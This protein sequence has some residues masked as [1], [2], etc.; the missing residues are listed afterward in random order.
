MVNKSLLHDAGSAIVRTPLLWFFAIIYC[1]TLDLP[2]IV[3]KPPPWFIFLY[4]LLFPL[5]ILAPAC[6]IRAIQLQ[7]FSAAESV[8][9]IIR[10]CTRRI[11]ALIVV[12]LFSGLIALLLLGI[13]GCPLSLILEQ[14]TK[15]KMWTSI[16]DLASII[17]LPIMVFAQCAIVISSLPVRSSIL[18]LFKVIKKDT[19]TIL[20]LIVVFGVLRY[21]MGTI[22]PTIV[23]HPIRISGYLLILLILEGV[24]AAFFTIAYL[25]Y[26]LKDTATHQPAI[27]S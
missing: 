21:I 1:L 27:S 13:I 12:L 20:T 23:N 26:L 7:Y 25:H 4:I 17:A 11:G 6:Q 19:F 24:Q 10:F 14:E 22:Y 15:S 3:Y 2:T 9:Q 8:L 16:Y 5:I 18:M